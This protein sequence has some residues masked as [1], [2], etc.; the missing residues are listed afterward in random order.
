MVVILAKTDPK[1]R[2]EGANLTLD[3][4]YIENMHNTSGET[5]DE[6]TKKVLEKFV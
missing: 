1:G 2:N 3:D 4:I 5:T 6:A